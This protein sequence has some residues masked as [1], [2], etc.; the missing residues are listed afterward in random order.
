MFDVSSRSEPHAGATAQGARTALSGMTAQPLNFLRTLRQV[1]RRQ[2]SGSSRARTSPDA[3]GSS[4]PRGFRRFS[5]FRNSCTR[6]R[7]RRRSPVKPGPSHRRRQSGGGESVRAVHGAPGARSVRARR[8]ARRARLNGSSVRQARL[9]RP[10]PAP[11][12]PLASRGLF[13]PPPKF[14][15]GARDIRRTP[16]CPRPKPRR[17]CRRYSP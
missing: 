12:S 13:E 14:A 3:V 16:A 9:R 6:R 10:S 15:R 8:H 4:K 2:R 17:G 7:G 1:R 11:P 5:V